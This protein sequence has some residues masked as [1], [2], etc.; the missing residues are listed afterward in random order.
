MHVPSEGA[1]LKLALVGKFKQ[2]VTSEL[3]SVQEEKEADNQQ[4]RKVREE[5]ITAQATTCQLTTQTATLEQEL[6]VGV[7]HLTVRCWGV[8]WWG[9]GGGQVFMCV[10]VWGGGGCV[11]ACVCVSGGCLCMCVCVHVH[12][13]VCMCTCVCVC[14]NAHVN[15]E[16]GMSK[17]CIHEL[18]IV[19]AI[20]GRSPFCFE[21]GEGVCA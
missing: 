12:A 21:K 3:G 18:F 15:G 8:C 9:C 10:C 11:C 4:C 13:C 7:C 1:K 19:W 16:K 14:M 20:W 17:L 6:E 5:L 2:K